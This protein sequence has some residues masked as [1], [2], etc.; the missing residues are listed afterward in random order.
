MDLHLTH[1]TPGDHLRVFVNQALVG[2]LVVGTW[3]D[4]DSL[5]AEVQQA[6]YA[7]SLRHCVEALLAEFT[8]A[9]DLPDH[10]NPT[11]ARKIEAYS[12]G[13][14]AGLAGATVPHPGGDPFVAPIAP[15][16]TPS[17]LRG[18]RQGQALSWLQQALHTLAQE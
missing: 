7:R 6:R 12:R 15:E 5:A 4:R 10:R 17:Y 2:E 18:Y 16:Q 11:P 13:F 1:L 8:R 9:G 14:R 3:M